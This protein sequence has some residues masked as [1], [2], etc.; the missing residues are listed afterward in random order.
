MNKSK[1]FETELNFIQNEQIKTFA[2]KAINLLPD[3]FFEV[4]AS[5]TGKYHPQSSL[6]F[7]GLVRHT[8]IAVKFAAQMLGLEQSQKMFDERQRD[9]MI[10]ALILHD[11]AK[12]GIPKTK[13]TITD[14]P[15]VIADYIS[16]HEALKGII[17]DEDVL[18]I[19]DCIRSHM[20]EFNT[21]FKTKKE[22]LPKPVTY[23]Q[24]FVHLCDYLAS[25]KWI[26]VDFEG[27]HYNEAIFK[28]LSNPASEYVESIIA[29]CKEKIASGV[30]R[31]V[32][33]Q[34]I[35][36]HSGRKNPKLITDPTVAEIVLTK[37]KEVK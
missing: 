4:P 3:Y 21:D 22:V 35:E 36:E 10:V 13:Y 19:C 27:N 2:I 24:E 23:A 6:G 11:G 7:G 33:Y 25:R 18:F 16:Q 5:S 8:K 20:G 30:D 9:L 14:H 34:I 26:N 31:E 17:P 1:V 37:I 15:L 28:A 29:L 12:S 32:L